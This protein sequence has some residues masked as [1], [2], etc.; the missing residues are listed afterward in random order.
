MKATALLLSGILIL[1]PAT[2]LGQD[3]AQCDPGIVTDCI[4]AIE[5]WEALCSRLLEGYANQGVNVELLRSM[6]DLL[7]RAVKA[8]YGREEVAAVI[9]VMRGGTAPTT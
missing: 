6:R 4:T 7:N 9:K 2:T 5:T 3:P 1:W 8:G